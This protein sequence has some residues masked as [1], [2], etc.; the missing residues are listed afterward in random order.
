MGNFLQ[1]ARELFIRTVYPHDIACAICSSEVDV[2][3]GYG[4]CALCASR[5]P[6]VTDGISSGGRA[7][8]GLAAP[9]YYET[10]VKELIHRFKYDNKRYIAKGL[11]HYMKDAVEQ[12]GFPGM[13]AA[14]PVPLHEARA[15]E[16]GFNQAALLAAEL[17]PLLGIPMYEDVLARV[18]ETRTQTLLPREEREQN[19]KDAFAVP[20]SVDVSGLTLLLVDDVVTTGA[21]V[22]AAARTL[23]AAG[24]R[25]VYVASACTRALE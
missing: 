4:V 24:A 12:A 25:A 19:V 8:D 21:T 18:Q 14:A 3:P 22:E 11:A 17:A 10:P 9:F 20:E 7:F 15:K 2:A 6:R 23:K 5:L 13:D 1:K 16:R